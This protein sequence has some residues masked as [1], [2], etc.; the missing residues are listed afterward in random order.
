VQWAFSFHPADEELSGGGSI[1]QK[2]RKRLL[3]LSINFEDTISTAA[4]QI[5]SRFLFWRPPQLIRGDAV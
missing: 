5:R 4:P 1:D 2:P 3:F